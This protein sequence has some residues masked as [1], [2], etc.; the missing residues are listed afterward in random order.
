MKKGSKNKPIVNKPKDPYKTL[1][2][3]RK[4]SQ[5]QIKRAYFQLVRQYPPETEAEKFQEIRAAYEQL[6]TPEK[7][8]LAD[9][10]LLQPPPEKPNLPSINYDL[11]IHK[12][13]IIK[14][15]LEV[16]LAEISFQKDFQNIKI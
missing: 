7:R 1:E 9:L 3:D 14:L 4:A 12:E 10:F 15:A 11:S 8:A 6:R 16:K 2:L 5:E 13:D